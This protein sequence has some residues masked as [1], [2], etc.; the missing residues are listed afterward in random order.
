MS[1]ET[2]KYDDDLRQKYPVLV[3]MDEV[4][5]GTLAGP[6]VTAA[7]ILPA[8]VDIPEVG[9]SKKINK[10]YHEELARKIYDTAVEVQ[11]GIKNAQEIDEYDILEADRMAMRDAIANLT[12]T[13][14]LIL[15]DGDNKQLLGTEYPEKTLVKGDAH[16]L[17]VGAASLIAKYVRDQIMKDYD[18]IYPGFGFAKNSGYAT[19]QHREA[20]PVLGV[21]PI[22][23][24]TFEPIKS[25]LDTWP[26]YE[27]R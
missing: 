16:S 11:I 18:D 5:R 20:L 17:S 19:K 26:R 13:P 3:G 14:S 8:G 22:H 21:T 2:L 10:K 24:T 23:R 25:H 27:K 1:I 15:I 6:V 12:S 7:V 4:G 9:D